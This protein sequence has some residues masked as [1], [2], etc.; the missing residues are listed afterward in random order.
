[1]NQLLICK[2]VL[3]LKYQFHRKKRFVLEDFVLDLGQIK[4]EA[5]H[6]RNLIIGHL[7]K[8]FNRF[9]AHFFLRSAFIL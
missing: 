7:R 6:V 8:I 5:K 3:E 4:L 2:N 9:S 1:M